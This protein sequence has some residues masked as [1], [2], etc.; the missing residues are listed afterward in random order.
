MSANALTGKTRSVR[1]CGTDYVI[2]PGIIHG[3]KQAWQVEANGI[4]LSGFRA[5]RSKCVTLIHDHAVSDGHFPAKL[6]DGVD[7]ARLVSAVCR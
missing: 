3:Q 2:R 4:V 7:Y 1:Y 5:T 6:G